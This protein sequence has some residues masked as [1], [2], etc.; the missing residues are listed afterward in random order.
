M[1][2][3][4]AC[5]RL[6]RDRQFAFQ[7]IP[8]DNFG[9]DAVGQPNLNPAR[10][11]L[12][13][14]AQD[15]DYA[16]LTFQHW[17]ACRR[18]VALTL[19]GAGLLP[20]ALPRLA[21]LI[22]ARCCIAVISL[23]L[24]TLSSL[25]AVSSSAGR[26]DSLSR[27]ICRRKTKR[28]VWN[29][30]HVVPLVNRDRQVCRHAWLQ[31]LFRIGDVNDDVVSDDVLHGHRIESHLLNLAV[32]ILTRECIDG[33]LDRLRLFNQT[34][35]GLIDVGDDLHLRQI[36]GDCEKSRSRQTGGNCLAHVNVTRNYYT[37]DGRRYRRVGQ[38]YFGQAKRRFRLLHLRL[39]LLHLRLRLLHLCLR[40]LHLRL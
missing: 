14:L 9:R 23:R 16:R 15:P 5:Q 10:L 40:L 36:F 8:F 1:R 29:L 33:K 26:A 2:L 19:L 6:A 22:R 18:K 17:C 30:K 38:I 39:C 11:Q 37:V 7:Q 13:V 31:F 21:S 20:A 24:R 3:T 4:G 34:N 35:V 25:A 12:A 32:V 27:S 28:S